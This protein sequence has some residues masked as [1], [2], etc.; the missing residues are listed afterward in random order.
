MMAAFGFTDILVLFCIMAICFGAWRKKSLAVSGAV[1]AFLLTSAL[2]VLGGIPFLAPLLV[3]FISS[4]LLTKWKSEKKE[5]MEKRLYE[6]SGTRDYAQVLANGGAGLLIAV[7]YYINPSKENVLALFTA[8]AACNA[9]TWASEVGI[10][11]RSKP[12]S[13]L[14]LK[15]VQRGISGGVSFLGLFASL[16]GA[17]LISGVYGFFMFFKFTLTELV[18]SC[19]IITVSGFA[20]SLIDSVLG[21]TLQPAYLEQASGK[22]TEKKYNNGTK[23]TKVK[24]FEFFS[25]DMVNFI[26]SLA[27]ACLALIVFSLL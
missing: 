6:K 23:N 3:F 18:I 16:F 20:G 9:D 11:S 7:L 14:T 17:G 8:F 12:F 2:Y 4:S 1:T 15:P 25:N 24:G 5:P 10:L 19:F 27:A 13:I 21:V 26:S 22:L